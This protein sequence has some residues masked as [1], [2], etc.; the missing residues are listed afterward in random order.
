MVTRNARLFSAFD[1][2]LATAKLG[3]WSRH[4]CHHN[5]KVYIR[6]ITTFRLML[7][8]KKGDGACDQV[9][10]FGKVWAFLG[11]A[12][13]LVLFRKNVFWLWRFWQWYLFFWKIKRWSF[14]KNEN[15]FWQN[16][17]FVIALQ[18]WNSFTQSNG[19][20]KAVLQ[21]TQI[22]GS[23][24]IVSAN[25]F[26]GF[27]F[28]SISHFEVFTAP[29]QIEQKKTEQTSNCY[30]LKKLTS[31]SVSFVSFSW[32]CFGFCFSRGHFFP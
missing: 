11:I 9:W 3:W 18:L 17:S 16:V 30:S 22:E 2:H 20:S 28:F 14:M 12:Y 6:F 8:R 32:I 1:N 26:F 19:S 24:V 27:F 10:A 25:G 23:S 15:M 7:M 29:K 31:T 13:R 21:V 5:R 4:L